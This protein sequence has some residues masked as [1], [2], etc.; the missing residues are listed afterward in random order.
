MKRMIPFWM[1]ILCLLTSCTS[2]ED[3]TV[4]F[5]QEINV[6]LPNCIVGYEKDGKWV[7]LAELGNLSKS[8]RSKAFTVT[9]ESISEVYFFTDYELTTHEGR[10]YANRV[11]D[12]FILKK[13]KSNHFTLPAVTAFRRVP[14]DDPAEYP[15]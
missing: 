15:R 12:P 5:T 13:G 14:I 11:I 3:T 7:K 2:D 6:T 4:S 10:T 9:D 8:T 1:L